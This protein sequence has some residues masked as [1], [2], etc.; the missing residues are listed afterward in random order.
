MCRAGLSLSQG[1]LEV[2]VQSMCFKEFITL[3]HAALN[4]DTSTLQMSFTA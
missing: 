1:V 2:S 3:R 4:L